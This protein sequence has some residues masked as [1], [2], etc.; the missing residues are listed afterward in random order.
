MNKKNIG[1]R[2]N[3]ITDIIR[4]VRIVSTYN[5]NIDM[6]KINTKYI[7]DAKSLLGVISLD[8]TKYCKL[9]FSYT[10]EKRLEE[11]ENDIR[12]FVSN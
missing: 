3:T 1:I 11:F 8:P 10:E 12:E 5:E 6:I 7:V 9:I 4:F 2:L